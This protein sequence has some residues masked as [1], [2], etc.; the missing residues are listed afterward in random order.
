MSTKT[1]ARL[2]DSGTDDSTERHPLREEIAE[3]APYA[4]DHTEAGR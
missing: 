1:A 4:A 2:E 3:A